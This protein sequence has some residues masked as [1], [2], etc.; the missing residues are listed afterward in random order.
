MRVPI[1]LLALALCACALAQDLPNLIANGDFARSTEGWSVPQSE[2]GKT[3]VVAADTDGVKQAL[4]VDLTPKAGTNPW[5]VS[6]GQRIPTALAKGDVLR[7]RLWLRSPQ[8]CPASVLLQLAHDPWST[9]IARTVTALPQWR[10]Y[11]VQGRCAEDH[12][13]DD[14]Q[15]SLQLAHQAGQ[16]DIAAIRVNNLGPSAP[17]RDLAPANPLNLIPFVLPWDDNTP[18]ITNVSAWLD[19]PAGAKGFV[20]PRDGH[21]YTGD[22]RLRFV[23]TCLLYTSPSPRDS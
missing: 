9:V 16:I 4:R 7:V 3:N 1:V 21:L 23:G 17:E 10:E 2:L 8:S 13:A 18:S 15:L 6:V 19:K 12:P 22:A 14:V 11:T 20:V 5:D